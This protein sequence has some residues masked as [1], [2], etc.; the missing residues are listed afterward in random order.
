MSHLQSK[1]HKQENEPKNVVETKK[2]VFHIHSDA[3][4]F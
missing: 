1:Q 2:Y 4:I 3:C